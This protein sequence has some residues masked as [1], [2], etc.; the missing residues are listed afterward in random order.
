LLPRQAFVTVT[1]ATRV[2]SVTKD[3]SYSLRRGIGGQH[4]VTRPQGVALAAIKH[5]T[6]VYKDSS[7]RALETLAKARNSPKRLLC[8]LSSSN[9]Q[10]ELARSSRQV[11]NPF[12]QP[13]IQDKSNRQRYAS[14]QLVPDERTWPEW[15]QRQ[16]VHWYLPE[17]V[18]SKEWRQSTSRKLASLVR[19][20]SVKSK[21]RYA[22]D[23]VTNDHS[24]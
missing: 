23:A 12:T 13:S 4:S 7:T 14:V 11:D 21:S 2:F 22:P 18:I 6:I 1:E 19:Q 17:K 5:R 3:S 9:R 20:R 8:P 15:Q 24:L 10:L 16:K